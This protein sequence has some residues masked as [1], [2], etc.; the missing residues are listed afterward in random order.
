VK[1]T[2]RSKV[3]PRAPSPGLAKLCVIAALL[4]TSAITLQSPAT[5]APTGSVAVPTHNGCTWSPG[6][7]DT[8]GT[9]PEIMPSA[10]TLIC[11]QTA[12]SPTIIKNLKW[13]Q[14]SATGATATGDYF[15][16][17]L[18]SLSSKTC[19]LLPEGPTKIVVS[20]PQSFGGQLLFSRMAMTIASAPEISGTLE[21][22][23]TRQFINSQV[24]N[25]VST[26]TIVGEMTW[27][28]LPRSKG[29]SPTSSTSSSPTTTTTPL[30]P[31]GRVGSIKV[32]KIK[33]PS[34]GYT[35]S[36]TNY[37]LEVSWHAP[38]KTGGFPI[39]GYLV[40]LCN[41]QQTDC[42]DNGYFCPI[43]T[44]THC[45]GSI[46]STLLAAQGLV[47]Q[48]VQTANN[49][50]TPVLSNLYFVVK[51][52]TRVGVSLK[53][54]SKAF[55]F[56]STPCSSG[57]RPLRCLEWYF[58]ATPPDPNQSF[59]PWVADSTQV[60]DL[61]LSMVLGDLGDFPSQSGPASSVLNYNTSDSNEYVCMRNFAI[62]FTKLSNDNK[63]VQQAMSYLNPFDAASWDGGA[64]NSAL[65]GLLNQV[66]EKWMLSPTGSL[67]AA[68]TGFLQAN[69]ETTAVRAALAA[70]IG[71]FVSAGQ[72][73]INQNIASQAWDDLST[74]LNSANPAACSFSTT[75]ER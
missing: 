17:A 9:M 48:Y 47:T 35:Y 44:Q 51:A 39:T 61:L 67:Q 75:E 69:A 53:R 6:K 28:W 62:S 14:W 43:T 49:V 18:K 25:R 50:T 22:S 38:K 34:V 10:I 32:S 36:P 23:P 11:A 4:V 20:F 65:N 8:V 56:P 46:S 13:S 60:Q 41:E 5:A 71:S 40:D 66:I 57:Q 68:L 73:Q 12:Q 55:S 52:R 19:Y 45:S 1:N 7:G 64:A 70:V 59:P 3:R 2:S 42:L 37:E 29:Q 72:A 30:G 27:L 24:Y 63:F 58:P 74:G 15:T 26:S 33:V 31:P 16:C 54:P 21:L